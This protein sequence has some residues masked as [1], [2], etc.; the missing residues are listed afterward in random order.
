MEYLIENSILIAIYSI[1]AITLNYVAGYAGILSIAHGAFFGIGA[2]ST[3]ILT[4]QFGFSFIAAATLGILITMLAAA[5]S[6]I[7][8]LRL[9]GDSLMLVSFGFA[10]I[11]FNIFINWTNLTDGALG[12]K[13]IPTPEIFG[14]SFESRPLFLALC[15][16]TAIIIYLFFN[17]IGKSPYGRVL[18]GIRENQDVMANSGHDIQTYKHSAFI[19]GS[20]A[21]AIAGALFATNSPYIITP[22]NFELMQSVLILI[23]IIA[24]GFG[25]IRGAVLG[26]IVILL[27]PELLRFV[28][29]PEAE[30]RQIFY[31]L[32]LISLM[33]FR[34]QGLL[35]KY[36]I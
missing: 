32:I 4:T 14:F 5:I 30:Y 28:G 16:F 21:A 13:N 33:Y 31:G 27:T 17:H 12:I 1:L 34:P 3:A 11:A 23:I 22:K 8:I 15:I 36:K 29:L 35:G 7:F 18:K 24:G 25:N 26:T 10:I 6:S 20:T 9:K 2:Y 19:L